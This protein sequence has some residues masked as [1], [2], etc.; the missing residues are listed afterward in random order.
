MTYIYKSPD[1]WAGKITILEAK[2]E[3]LM[4]EI[5]LFKN[6]YLVVAWF[7]LWVGLYYNQ[8]KKRLYIMLPFIGIFI[9]F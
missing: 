5:K 6:V 9:K 7:D 3:N 1:N 4:K 2:K 8:S